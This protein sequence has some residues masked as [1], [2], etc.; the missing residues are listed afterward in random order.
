[1]KR[2]QRTTHMLAFLACVCLGSAAQAAPSAKLTEFMSYDG[3]QKIKVQGIDLAYARP[4][5]TLAGYKKIELA[6]INVSFAKN[7][8]PKTPNGIFPLNQSE[9]DQIKHNVANLVR[10]SF[11]N[12]LTKGGYPIVT[13]SGP[14]VLLVVAD[15][16]NLYVANP[17]GGMTSGMSRTYS[18]EAGQGTLVIELYDSETGQVLARAIDQ[19]QAQSVGPMIVSNTVTQRMQAQAVADRWASILLNSLEKAHNIGKR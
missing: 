7:W 19:R 2:T 4:G 17:G 1:M 8:N 11:V 12:K 6:P 10:D 9:R 18:V 16:I 5:A 13:T 3:L 14:D 15:I